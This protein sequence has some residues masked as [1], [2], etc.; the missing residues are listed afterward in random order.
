VG[1]GLC[2]GRCLDLGLLRALCRDRSLG[3]SRC[4]GLGFRALCRD[5]RLE[6]SPCLGLGF[7][8]LCRDRRLELS[9]CLHRALTLVLFRTLGASL[10]S[11]LV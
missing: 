1:S 9:P 2:L 3:L 6:L 4:L 11:W 10:F 8:A 7:R 5:R